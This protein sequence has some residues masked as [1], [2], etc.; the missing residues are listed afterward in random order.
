MPFE[1]FDTVRVTRLL[2]PDRDV[3]GSSAE[4]PQPRVGE[5]GVVV[6]VLG[7]EVYL[8]ERVTDDGYT[9]WLAEF[10]EQELVLARRAGHADDHRAHTD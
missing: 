10:G 2:V 1:L 3:D 7:D 8:V 6:E 9:L 4:P 5:E